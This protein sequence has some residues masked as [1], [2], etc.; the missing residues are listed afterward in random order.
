MPDTHIADLTIPSPAPCAAPLASLTPVSVP[1]PY[2]QEPCPRRQAA[3]RARIV[4]H[5]LV[6]WPSVTGTAGEAGFAAR[7]QALLLEIPYFRDHPDQIALVESHGSAACSVVAL[8]RGTGRRCVAFAGHYDTV[9]VSD[10][11][12]RAN[13]AGNAA[14]LHHALIQDLSDRALDPDEKLALDDLLSG[15]FIPGRGMLDMKSGI[16]A[17]LAALER[18]AMLEHRPGNLLIAMTPDEENRSRGMRSLRNALPDLARRWN[19]DIVAGINLDATSDQGDGTEGRSLYLGTVGKLLPF[20]FVI[21]QPAH[22]CYPF[23]GT[24]AHMIGAEILREIEANTDLC[25]SV[26]DELAPPPVCLEWKDL[27]E[28][29]DVTTPE[30]AWLAFNWLTTHRRPEEVM[31]LFRAAVERAMAEASA[32]IARHAALAQ[33]R[34]G[35]RI[36]PA[37]GTGQVISFAALKTRAFAVGGEQTINAHTELARL[38]ATEENP[39]LVSRKLVDHLVSAARLEG[40]CVVIGFGSLHYPHT[41]VDLRDP[42]QARVLRQMEAATTAVA[43][44][45]GTS[46]RRRGFFA[47]ISDMSFFGHLP[48]PVDAAFVAGNTPSEDFVDDARAGALR[49][50]VVNIGPW[51]REY[52]QPLER[53]HAGYAFGVLPDLLF[54][55]AH[56]VL[57]DGS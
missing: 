52:H 6:S 32:R 48:C 13:L 27:R 4:A 3:Q 39:L 2:W 40:P 38:L 47:G 23:E 9:S 41:Y 56:A 20:A 45:H 28:S 37:G 44:T 46:F 25:D 57:R 53:L 14:A 5:T 29:Y 12:D 35:T 1:A 55:A 22:A 31:A 19:L 21:G 43:N 33:G 26:L 8:V 11:G 30:R 54:E 16:A 42:A 34:G 24:S 51:G 50:P 7:L 18:Y 49:F 36:R 10:Y 15:E 17:G